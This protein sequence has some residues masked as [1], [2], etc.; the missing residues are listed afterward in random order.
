VHAFPSLVPS[1][2]KDM[3]PKELAVVIVA[4]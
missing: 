2:A 3:I 1:K 4:A